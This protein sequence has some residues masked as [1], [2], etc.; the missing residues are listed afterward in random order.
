MYT[1]SRNRIGANL[2][3][4]FHLKS[5]ICSDPTPNWAPPPKLAI[6]T[7]ISN[8][9]RTGAQAA[10]AS[11]CLLKREGRREWQITCPIHSKNAHEMVVARMRLSIL[12]KINASFSQ[13]IQTIFI[14]VQQTGMHIYTHKYWA[15]T[16][17]PVQQTTATLVKVRVFYSCTFSPQ[18]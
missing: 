17:F 13:V 14:W 6:A 3:Q 9:I 11:V 2:L 1:Y 12:D 4:Y 10:E 18:T 7:S 16:I 5:V 8:H 15:H